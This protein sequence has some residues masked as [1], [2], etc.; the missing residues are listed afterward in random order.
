LNELE[1]ALA[2]ELRKVN[3]VYLA[4]PSDENIYLVLKAELLRLGQK[5]ASV[6]S[7]HER[8]DIVYQKWATFVVGITYTA[9]R[10]YDGSLWDFIEDALDNPGVNQAELS[11]LYKGGL[12]YFGLARFNNKAQKNISEILLHS[13]IP[14]RS[15]E[16][17]VSGL[18]RQYQ[19]E[20]NLL[21]SDFNASIVRL[22]KDQLQGR[23]F[24]V[25]TWRFVTQ[26]R[27]IAEDLTEKCLAVVDD[28]A[29]GEHDEGGG[30]G[31]PMPLLE[32]IVALAKEKHATLTRRGGAQHFRRYPGVQ[33]DLAT[34]ELLV[35]LPQYEEIFHKSIHWET[36][37]GEAVDQF[38]LHPELGG[39][40]AAPHTLTI[41][42]L[43]QQIQIQ[44]EVDIDPWRI[45]LFDTDSPV[46]FFRLTGAAL[47]DSGALPR[48]E[49]LVLGP[50]SRKQFGYQLYFDDRLAAETQDYGTPF[51]WE[52]DSDSSQWKIQSFDLS[53]V[54][55]VALHKD[56]MEILDSVRYVGQGKP[57]FEESEAVTKFLTRQGRRVFGK[58]PRILLPSVPD[59]SEGV[60]K[61]TVRM[62]SMQA[63]AVASF[64]K[65]WSKDSSHF[66]PVTRFDE[67]DF[68]IIVEGRRGGAQR[69]AGFLWKGVSLE[70]NPP[71]RQ[72]VES[73]S[74]LEDCKFSIFIQGA[75]YTSGTMQM[76]PVMAVDTPDGFSL[77]LRP[78]HVEFH[79][80]QGANSDR[81]I[82]MI[83]LNA[84]K[85]TETTIRFVW[86]GDP[87]STV[88]LLSGNQLVQSLQIKG[89]KTHS[90]YVFLGEC[91]DTIK[92]HGQVDVIV[93]CGELQ[94]RVATIHPQ[95]I[96]NDVSYSADSSTLSVDSSVPLENLLARIYFLDAPWRPSVQAV[97]I[98]GEIS[99]PASELRLGK[100]GISFDISD[101]WAPSI[102]AA[103]F[104]ETG[105]SFIL[106]PPFKIE[107]Q[108]SEEAIANW[109]YSG[110]PL[111]P[112]LEIET[113]LLVRFVV[114]EAMASAKVARP[115]VRKFALASAALS[116]DEFVMELY[117]QAGRYKFDYLQL[118]FELK[119]VGRLVSGKPKFLDEGLASTSPFLFLSSVSNSMWID[120]EV[121]DRVLQE[122]FGKVGLQVEPDFAIKDLGLTDRSAQLVEFAE[123]VSSYNQAL[124]PEDISTIKNQL[125]VMPGPALHKARLAHAFVDLLSKS[126]LVVRSD[127]GADFSDEKTREISVGARRTLGKYPTAHGLLFN[128]RRSSEGIQQVS[129][130]LANIPSI[131]IALALLARFG[132][133]DA[134]IAIQYQTHA[135]LHEF[136]AS[137]ITP[138]V[139]FD[140][141][142]A[143][144][145]ASYSFS[146]NQEVT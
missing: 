53:E 9:W 132:A 96:V 91:S 74:N 62:D 10:E 20:E 29:D 58:L 48:E 65:P 67:G 107:P 11:S 109:F 105:D 47:P 14:Y 129:G 2:A 21:A 117:A 83:R 19:E 27:E 90:P 94:S 60:W 134:N 121:R 7:A 116:I 111:G 59:G 63:N 93:E 56:G 101:L 25:P 54:K 84:E 18:I 103:E 28:L 33:I 139:E 12:D 34:L 45:Q 41:S 98:E 95:K 31:L 24:D 97:W 113:P 144:L 77:E 40:V 146:K 126:S 125:G 50:M 81:R 124:S 13:G 122:L 73:G 82:S 49:I 120:D 46:S 26:A 100:L 32:R 79:V 70:T 85:A 44:S 140:L 137:T 89:A 115:I 23:G 119:A 61:I 57:S 145:I 135:P 17:F 92:K 110:I 1:I 87:I 80:V 69:V 143:E 36:L 4:F 136:L 55:K 66:D 88:S 5:M 22:R 104:L 42:K 131:S 30:E 99:I 3:L 6:S 127:F 64:E 123:M 37:I 112:E 52:S 114:D 38:S 8:R 15:Q 102:W 118:L 142:V 141:I 35:V 72:L 71:V 39:L 75:K 51:G 130:K 76:D 138:L 106:S 128:A 86:P 108:T 68:Q 78:A 43:C 16:G 133:R